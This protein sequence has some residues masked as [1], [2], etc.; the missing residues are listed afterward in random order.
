M[1]TNSPPPNHL[2]EV[3][4]TF[5]TPL[6]VTISL[7]TV[8]V[9]LFDL[10]LPANNF[11]LGTAAVCIGLFA[12][13]T[14]SRSVVADNP[15]QKTVYAVIANI[16]PPPKD[17]IWQVPKLLAFGIAVGIISAASVISYQKREHG[18]WLASNSDFFKNVQ[19]TL[20]GIKQDTAAIKTGVQSIDKKLDVLVESAQ[21]GRAG[22][23]IE[24]SEDARKEL[25][26]RGVA[27]KVE[28]FRNLIEQRDPTT[29]ALFL[30]GGLRLEATDFI[31]FVGK[32][33]SKELA[34]L[35]VRYGSFDGAPKM[36]S[37][38][39]TSLYEIALKSPDSAQFVKAVCSKTELRNQLANR[40]TELEKQLVLDQQKIA[41][42]ANLVR[43]CVNTIRR[44]LPPER[45]FQEAAMFTPML[46]QRDI[47]DRIKAALYPKV[48]YGQQTQKTYDDAVQSA[49]ERESQVS[50]ASS[51]DY[52]SLRRIQAG[53]FP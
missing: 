15:Q 31:W 35:M 24:T 32:H 6:S 23:K 19:G 2:P 28:N 38:D 48:M 3:F 34:D 18:G 43:D 11:L 5:L 37:V 21:N 7:T 39:S 44:N 14:Y 16:F 4:R 41:N 20:T 42:H 46:P 1:N 47:E 26:S 9:G 52:E 10:L 8:A 29:A 53:L 36:C 49:C 12:I 40:L 17:P 25:Q 50:S 22:G 13:V 30:Q 33:F 51:N 27:W 45:M